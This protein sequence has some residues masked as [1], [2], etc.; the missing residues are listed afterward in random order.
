MENFTDRS[1]YLKIVSKANPL[2]IIVPEM[3]SHEKAKFFEIED[4]C[5]VKEASNL[6]PPPYINIVGN[7]VFGTYN[8]RGQRTSLIDV[9]PRGIDLYNGTRIKYFKQGII[10]ES[11][12]FGTGSNLEFGFVDILGE[13]IDFE[14]L[15]LGVNSEYYI[16]IK[17]HF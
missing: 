1:F 2:Q 14:T 8:E 5:W 9:V 13:K 16:S 7:N 17:I 12:E 10:N 15:N 6:S 4:F 3:S 11:F